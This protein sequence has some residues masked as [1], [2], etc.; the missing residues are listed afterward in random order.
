VVKTEESWRPDSNGMFGVLRRISRRRLTPR[1][2]RFSKCNSNETITAFLLSKNQSQWHVHQQRFMP[3]EFDPKSCANDCFPCNKEIRH[4]GQSIIIVEYW[5]FD[6]H[7]TKRLSSEHVFLVMVWEIVK[8]WRNV[9]QP[10]IWKFRQDPQWFP[11]FHSGDSLSRCRRY[12]LQIQ[13]GYWITFSR[14]SIHPLWGTIH[15]RRQPS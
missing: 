8:L 3:I 13:W 7:I 14:N 6:C 11:L 1:S 10:V 15:S 9:L 4:M 2:T 12:F 5:R